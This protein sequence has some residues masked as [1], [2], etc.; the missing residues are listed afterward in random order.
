MI[1]TIHDNGTSRE[2]L[3]AQLTAVTGH[4]EAARKALKEA[5][6][7]ARDYYPQGPGAFAKAASQHEAWGWMLGRLTGEIV[8]LTEAIAD[9]EGPR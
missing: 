5:A 6:P 8:D 3:I 4:L 7:N 1:P 9:A 2:R